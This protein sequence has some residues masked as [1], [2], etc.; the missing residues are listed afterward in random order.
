MVVRSPLTKP[1]E[2]PTMPTAASFDVVE[3]QRPDALRT[4]SLRATPAPQARSRA[5]EDELG[6]LRRQLRRSTARNSEAFDQGFAAAVDM[7]A[8]GATLDRLR[9]ASGVV[10]REFDDTEPMVIVSLAPRRCP[11]SCPGSS[12]PFDDEDPTFVDLPVSDR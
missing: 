7:V 3:R 11:T 12:G 4:R 6:R 1:K 10:A 9:D 8:R 5:D 2:R